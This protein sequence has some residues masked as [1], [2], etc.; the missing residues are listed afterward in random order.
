M[1]T[2]THQVATRLYTENSEFQAL[3]SSNHVI[4]SDPARA[5]CVITSVVCGRCQ[6]HRVTSLT[7]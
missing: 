3:A 7:R 4:R 2:M 5:G 6:T 1:A